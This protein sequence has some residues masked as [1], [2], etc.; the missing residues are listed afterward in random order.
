MGPKSTE[1][2]TMDHLGAHLL[3]KTSKLAHYG[4]PKTGFMDGKKDFQHEK[5]LDSDI[6]PKPGSQQG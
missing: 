4:G 1:G 3:Y 2:E 6:K 5:A